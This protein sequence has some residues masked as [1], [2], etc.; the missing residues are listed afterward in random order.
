MKTISML[1]GMLLAALGILLMCVAIIGIITFVITI[2][3]WM[4]LWAKIGL[5]CIGA[6]CIILYML[7]KESE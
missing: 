3:T 1:T 5:A 4:A 6:S 7:K 2:F